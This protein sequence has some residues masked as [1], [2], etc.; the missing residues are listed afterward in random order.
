[1]VEVGVA[2]L[3]IRITIVIAG[4]FIVPEGMTIATLLSITNSDQTVLPNTIPLYQFLPNR[5]KVS[6][7]HPAHP[8]LIPNS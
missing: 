5:Y 4:T 6:F 2:F 1:L 3:F 8:L 7:H